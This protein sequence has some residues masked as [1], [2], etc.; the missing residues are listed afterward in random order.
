MGNPGHDCSRDWCGLS[1]SRGVGKHVQESNAYAFHEGRFEL[2][3]LLESN[4]ISGGPVFHLGRDQRGLFVGFAGV[5]E[6]RE[7]CH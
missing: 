1:V 3:G 6:N 2:V 7:H 4:G 5:G